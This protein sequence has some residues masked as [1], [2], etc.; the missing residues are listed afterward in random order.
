MLYMSM[1][2]AFIAV[3]HNSL[4]RV[5]FSVNVTRYWCFFLS[6]K[7]CKLFKVPEK[8]LYCNLKDSVSQLL[9]NHYR[10]TLE[11]FHQTKM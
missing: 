4:N 7:K 10:L 5:I 11:K 8:S 1:K 6:L 3:K 9:L 2:T